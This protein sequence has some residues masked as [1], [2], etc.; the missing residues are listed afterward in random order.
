MLPHF[1]QIKYITH[2]M[3]HAMPTPDS[4]QWM[5]VSK[6]KGYPFTSDIRKARRFKSYEAAERCMKRLR[7]TADH[8]KQVKNNCETFGADDPSI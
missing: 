5:Y 7:A 6:E 1:H 8:W 4:S 3:I 2:W